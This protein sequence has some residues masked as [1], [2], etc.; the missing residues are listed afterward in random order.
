MKLINSNNFLFRN[1]KKDI[2]NKLFL[3][4]VFFLASAPFVGTIVLL[5]PLA[6]GIIKKRS[7]ILRDKYNI[8]L[9]VVSFIMVFKCI[10]GH[11]NQI[12]FLDSWDPILN[13]IGLLN[14]IPLFLCFIGFQPYLDS[15]Q[16]RLILSKVFI[17]S[18][19]PILISGIAQFFFKINGPF[20]LM[21]GLVVWYQ[22]PIDGGGLTSLF[23]N[24]N[25]AG[26]WLTLLFPLCLSVLFI[27][28]KKRFK[29]KSIIALVICITF[30]TSIVLTNSRGAWIGLIV[31]IPIVL[32]RITL[33]WLMPLILILLM[34]ILVTF[35]PNMPLQYKEVMMN[36]IPEK[37]F[38]KFSEIFLNLQ[39]FPR[40]DIWKKSLLFISNRPFLGWGASTFSILYFQKTNLFNNHAHNLF[41]ELSINY[42]IIVSLIIF[43]AI[44]SI[45]FNSY[46]FIFKTENNL[47]IIN[48]RSWWAATLIFILSHLYDVLYYDLRISISSWIFIAGL[49]AII[50]ENKCPIN[51]KKDLIY[52]F[53]KSNE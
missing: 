42:G 18:S 28:R 29:I 38:S 46:F 14:W 39:A 43:L 24:P 20:Q 33:F 51:L 7:E 1:I 6:K 13:W 12:S 23:N 52:R 27:N 9:I 3:L 5:Y 19:I 37:V 10:N 40:L 22:R 17:A 31:S 47:E 53:F 48:D 34:T 50:I 49:R 15:V 11:F 16:K 25:Y 41:L 32:G 44:F 35:I 26:G 8:A 21:N 4:G 2:D 30:T 36:F 45:L